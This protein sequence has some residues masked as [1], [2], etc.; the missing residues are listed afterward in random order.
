MKRMSEVFELPTSAALAHVVM[1]AQKQGVL[2]IIA[3]EH[4]AHAINHVDALA[5]ALEEAT[6][7]LYFQYDLH[8]GRGI[9]DP[10]IKK[11]YSALKAYRGEK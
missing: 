5:D 9:D 10:V 11:L 6:A 7:L 1:G 2:P 8:Y 4:T 3:D